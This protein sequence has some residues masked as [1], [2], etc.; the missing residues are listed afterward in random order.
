MSVK[1]LIKNEIEKLPENLL[2][3]VFD[4]IRF[5]EIKREK[6]LLTMASQK[7][8]MTSFEKVWDNEEDVIYDSL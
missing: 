6:I 8:S 2:E 5:L 1:D 7:L 3:E 4:F